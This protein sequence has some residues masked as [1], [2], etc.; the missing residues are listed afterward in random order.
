M[1]KRYLFI[2]AV[3]LS[4]I[5]AGCGSKSESSGSAENNTPPA[6]VETEQ[7]EEQKVDEDGNIIVDE[8]Y[9]ET[10]EIEAENTDEETGEI[11]GQTEVDFEVQTNGELLTVETSGGTADGVWKYLITDENVAVLDSE[12]D[13]E[14]GKIYTF[15]S[16]APG[17]AMIG[18]SFF[19]PDDE[20]E[21]TLEDVTEGATDVLVEIRVNDDLKMGMRA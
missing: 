14:D 7:E 17:D 15:K 9:E 4:L 18:I 3:G 16:K 5:M 10:G 13:T 12:E 1:K 19:L 20:A 11:V 8:Y 21:I 2:V 6:Q